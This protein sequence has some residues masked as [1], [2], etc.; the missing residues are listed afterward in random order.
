MR[1]LV[2]M[3]ILT[4]SLFSNKLQVEEVDK[5]L[6]AIQISTLTTENGAKRVIKDLSKYNTYLKRTNK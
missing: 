2:I 6:Y 1:I 4:L 5:S 3:F